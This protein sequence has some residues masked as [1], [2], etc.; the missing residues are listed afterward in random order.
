VYIGE[1][2]GP[3]FTDTDWYTTLTNASLRTG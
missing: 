1:E 3:H 2:T